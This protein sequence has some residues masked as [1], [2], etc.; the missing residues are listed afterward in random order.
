VNQMSALFN[1]ACG[2][3]LPA[4]DD[5]R[6]RRLQLIVAA[7]LMALALSSVWGLAAGSASLAI[8]MGNLL[9]VPL[10]VLLSSLAAVPAGMLA[11]KLS[12]AKVRGTQVMVSFASGVFCAAMVLAVLSPVVALYYHSSAWAGPMLAMGSVLLSIGVAVV[13]FLRNVF[14]QLEETVARFPVVIT[15]S[16]FLLMQLAAL[17]QLVALFS[18]I[19]PELTVFDGG[20][21][22]MM[23]R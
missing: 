7:M 22:R 12:G 19:L 16:V 13:I 18:P 10:I 14:G 15:V 2:Q 4:E 3:P 6:A 17:L 8:A 1:L 20:I 11:W 21:D 9:K 23:G 5:S